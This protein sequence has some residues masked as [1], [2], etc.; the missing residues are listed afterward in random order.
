MADGVSAAFV[1]SLRRLSLNEDLDTVPGMEERLRK[2]IEPHPK[3][4][5]DESPGPSRSSK[6]SPPRRPIPKG[7]SCPHLP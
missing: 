4:R 5:S 7:L 2:E 6:H 1:G 3:R